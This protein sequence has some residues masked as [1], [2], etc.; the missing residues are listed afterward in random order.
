MLYDSFK[1]NPEINE[2]LESK[3][4]KYSEQI[5]DMRIMLALTP[6]EIAKYLNITP[7]QYIDYE[8]CEL[9][10]PVIKYK[11]ML[12][13]LS[14]FLFTKD[15]SKLVKLKDLLNKHN[16]TFTQIVDE[17]T[18]S[19]ENEQ[20]CL[21]LH[22]K[23]YWEALIIDEE[24]YEYEYKITEEN[25]NDYNDNSLQEY[26]NSQLTNENISFNNFVNELDVTLTKN[27]KI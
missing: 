10:I 1:S 24:N 25:Y 27:K 16:F 14:L 18:I 13:N 8:Y 23:D 15:I 9:Y 12:T 2:K 26:E 11:E 17:Y 7:E 20:E 4:F 22:K 6:N 19:Y 21:I 5:M 3:A